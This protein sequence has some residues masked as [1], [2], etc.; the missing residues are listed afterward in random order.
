MS[1]TRNGSGDLESDEGDDRPTVVTCTVCGDDVG[2]GPGGL[3]TISHAN[4]HRRE[5]LAAFG[6]RPEDYAEVREV[7]GRGVVT[8]SDRRQ[9]T[10]AEALT[11]DE[12]A[13]LLEVNDGE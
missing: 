2:R 5:F 6:R 12:Q 1:D 9:L 3:G 8:D 11:D 10:L 7:L 4:R 13:S